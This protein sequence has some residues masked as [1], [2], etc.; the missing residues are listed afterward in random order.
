MV[1]TALFQSCCV[2]KTSAVRMA[3]QSKHVA[4]IM[5]TCKPVHNV[6]YHTYQAQT[7][8]K[9]ARTARRQH[10]NKCVTQSLDVL[11][12]RADCAKVHD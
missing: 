5:H 6:T 12:I 4:C 3:S 2:H 8:D 1:L 9:H 11:G 7:N 10:V